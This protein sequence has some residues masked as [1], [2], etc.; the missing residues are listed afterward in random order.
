M[1]NPCSY[2]IYLNYKCPKCDAIH[3]ATPKETRFPGGV[4][5]YCG[6]EIS[7]KEI[8]KINVKLHFK[9]QEK[10][11]D[12]PPIDSA[13]PIITDESALAISGLIKLG[14][15]AT[16]AK[17]MVKGHRGTAEEILQKVFNK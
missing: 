2:D 11:V 16:T 14:Y 17:E 9:K 6:K 12:K 10:V 8:E 1:E 13:R 5:C 15:K 3:E 7:F 4:L